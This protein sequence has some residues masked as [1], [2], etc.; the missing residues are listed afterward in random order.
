MP[1]IKS[2]DGSPFYIEQ[3]ECVMCGACEA[4]AP[5][6]ISHETVDKHSGT[7]FFKRQPE[8]PGEIDRAI[9]AIN[10]CCVSCIYY[11][12]D[13]PTVRRKIEAPFGQSN[14]CSSQDRKPLFERIASPRPN[15]AA[16]RAMLLAGGA[17]VAVSFCLA[18]FTSRIT[19]N[20]GRNLYVLLLLGLFF[21]G[22]GRRLS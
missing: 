18:V 8:T 3:I 2:T 21:I 14:C 19:E 12:G 5:D 17:L 13:D 4:V 11:R 16:G 22:A 10:G 9:R 20:Y 7:Y 15:I 6:L 1:E